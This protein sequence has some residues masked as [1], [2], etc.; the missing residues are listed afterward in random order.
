MSLQYI[1]DGYNIT[2]HRLFARIRKTPHDPLIAL[3]D[4]ILAKKLCGSAKNK[5]TL[6]F[7]GWPP[8]S[9]AARSEHAGMEIVFS[10]DATADARIRSM[11]E[12]AANVKTTVVV[13]DDREIKFF[14]S[15][16]G[17]RYLSIE[18]FLKDN[19]QKPKNE[20]AVKP[21]LTYTQMLE[22]NRELA[23]KWLK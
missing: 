19:Q 21:E 13:S 20:E 18:E 8:P 9:R 5:I 6:V 23:K 4:V 15:S 17:A 12:K 11:L 14:A 3:S 10:L 22:I 1:I 16:A 2:K 7:D